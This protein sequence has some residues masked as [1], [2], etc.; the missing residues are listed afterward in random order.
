MVPIPRRVSVRIDAVNLLQ[1]SMFNVQP[2][3]GGS[4]TVTNV[5]RRADA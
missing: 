5:A 3:A 2:R 4:V 1:D